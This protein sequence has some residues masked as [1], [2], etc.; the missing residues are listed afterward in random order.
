[1]LYELAHTIQS[2]FPFIWNGIEGVNS[3]LFSAKY[4]GKLKTIPSI[5][6]A[7]AGE[8]TLSEVQ[9]KDVFSLKEF[10]AT[11]PEQ[12]FS[13]FKP[14]GFD[15]KSLRRLVRR[16]SQLMLVAKQDGQ[17]VGYAFLR[18]FFNNKCFRGKIVDYRHRGK[19]IAVL[20]GKATT[21]ISQSL[22]IRMFGT[23]SKDNISSM[24]SSEA[25]NT[26]KIVE[27]LPNDYLYIEYLPK[28]E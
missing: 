27:E 1:M 16:K 28:K 22:G 3:A 4:R 9:E 14:H 13:Y 17:I 19:G 5:L 18:C 20:L 6:E 21:A 10:F 24:A 7:F 23:I 25:S 12:A 2:K 26:I 11:Q 15:E 8:Y